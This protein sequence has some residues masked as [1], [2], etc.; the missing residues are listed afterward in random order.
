MFWLKS[1]DFQSA[2]RDLETAVRL[3]P[4]D[5]RVLLALALSHAASSNDQTATRTAFEQL[6]AVARSPTQLR[7]LAAYS[8][9]NAELDRSLEFAK[10]AMDADTIDP[11]SLD[12]YAGTLAALGRFDEALRAQQD[13]LALLPEDASMPDFSQHLANLR[14]QIQDSSKKP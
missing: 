5:A 12:V 2:R 1:K 14:T 11:L 3:A 8:L 9:S 10:R 6:A 13:A 7:A 4:S